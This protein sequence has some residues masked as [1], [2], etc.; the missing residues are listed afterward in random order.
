MRAAAL[1]LCCTAAWGLEEEI[2][3]DTTVTGEHTLERPIRIT[4]DGITVDLG[5]AVLLGG[6]PGDPDRY[7]GIG[8]LIEGR[9]NV[10][11]RGGRLARFRSAVLV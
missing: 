9:R 1:L 10:T 7:E 5:E 8:L 11:V 2:A 6:A 4:A 3:A